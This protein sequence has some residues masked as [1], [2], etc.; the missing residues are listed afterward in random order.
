MVRH[1]RDSEPSLAILCTSA[2]LTGANLY[3]ADLRQAS[4][5]TREQIDGTRGDETTKLP[6]GIQRPARW[7]Q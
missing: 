7:S 2:D 6:E 5:L 1:Q 4:G 3:A